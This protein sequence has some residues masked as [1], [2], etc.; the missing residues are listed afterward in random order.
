MIGLRDVTRNLIE[1][2]LYGGTDE[3]IRTAQEKLE[4]PMTL[5]PQN[6]AS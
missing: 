4:K 2:Q 6:T 5:I 1:L 3:E